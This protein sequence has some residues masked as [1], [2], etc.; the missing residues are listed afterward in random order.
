MIWNDQSFLVIYIRPTI[1]SR[2]TEDE[3]LVGKVVKL[4]STGLK[5]FGG[6]E[7]SSWS[8]ATIGDSTVESD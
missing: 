2:E 6:N 1:R 3:M 8:L 7:E 4:R 5:G